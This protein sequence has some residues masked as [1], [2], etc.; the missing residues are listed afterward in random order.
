MS[1]KSRASLIA[2]ALVCAVAMIVRADTTV[3][4]D[5]FTRADE[6]PLASPWVAPD[7]AADSKF[8]LSSFS[9]AGQG[10]ATFQLMHHG[11]TYTDDQASEATLGGSN[12]SA[13][14]VYGGVAVDIQPTGQNAIVF[15]ATSGSYKISVMASGALTTTIATCAGTPTA[16]DVLKLS[17][18]STTYTG[19]V[20]GTEPGTCHGTDSTYASGR[21]GLWGYGG[22]GN[23]TLDNWTG[24]NVS[25]ASRR[26]CVIGGGIVGPGCPGGVN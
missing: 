25:A 12:P 24:S 2:L 19:T 26:G 7:G 10:G 14:G 16:G 15:G 17:R 6:N 20:G 18:S 21:A 8:L 3:A 1:S 11:D 13:V 23:Y 5:T 4:S 9:L 22:I